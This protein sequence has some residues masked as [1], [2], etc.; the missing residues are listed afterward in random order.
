MFKKS[1]RFLA[2]IYFTFFEKIFKKEGVTIHV[3]FDLTDFEFRG[4]FVFDSYEKEESKYLSEHLSP[5]AKVLELG[6]CLGFVSCLTNHLL[7]DNSQHVVLEANPKLIPWIHKNRNENGC[8]FIIENRIISKKKTNTFYIHDLIVGGSLKRKTPHSI[9]I[10]GI[11]FE[12]L[13]EKH[14]IDFDTLVMDIEGGELQILREHQEAIAS[15]YQIFMEI[16]PFANILN[17]EEAQE[18]ED[19]LQ[20]IGF[21]LKIRDGSFQIWE[22]VDTLEP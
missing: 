13:R 7:D 22:K 3:P 18:C 16:H 21:H 9:E 17:D 8:G 2:G 14:K 15:F 11:G 6:S 10:E 5:E 20:S 1:R 19:I 4:R 12:E